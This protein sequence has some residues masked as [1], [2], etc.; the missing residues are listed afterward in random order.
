MYFNVIK[1]LV[2]LHFVID[3]KGCLFL[4]LKL[5]KPHAKRRRY[6]NF[7]ISGRCEF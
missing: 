1:L 6:V 7:E 4:F 2:L 5:A 3:N